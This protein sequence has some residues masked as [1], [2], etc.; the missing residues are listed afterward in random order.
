MG[1]A[2]YV[3]GR[4][5]GLHPVNSEDGPHY[6]PLELK[7]RPPKYDMQHGDWSGDFIAKGG[8][9]IAVC[10]LNLFNAEAMAPIPFP[11]LEMIN[12]ATYYPGYYLKYDLTKDETIRNSN[13]WCIV[14]SGYEPLE[15]RLAKRW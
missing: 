2:N 6:L 3:S 15:N 4:L 1:R 11:S 9:G 5:Y 14:A 12:Q 13:H 7:Y 10:K 8:D